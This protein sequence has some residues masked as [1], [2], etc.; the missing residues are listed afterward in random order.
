MLNYIYIYICVYR[1]IIKNRMI[2]T[3]NSDHKNVKLHD[4]E[5]THVVIELFV[6]LCGMLKQYAVYTYFYLEILLQKTGL[7]G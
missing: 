6:Q 2:W 5:M 3:A 4:Q 1:F 7:S